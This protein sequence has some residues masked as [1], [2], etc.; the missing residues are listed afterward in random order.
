MVSESQL[1]Q[2]LFNLL[3]NPARCRPMRLTLLG[4]DPS[5]SY[6]N[7]CLGTVASLGALWP[8]VVHPAGSTTLDSD[9]FPVKL[10]GTFPDDLVARA[11]PLPLLVVPL[12]RLP[13]LAPPREACVTCGGMNERLMSR[14][15]MSERFITCGGMKKRIITSGGLWREREA[16]GYEPANPAGTAT[17]PSH[18]SWC[19]SAASPLSRL[20]GRPGEVVASGS[21]H[22]VV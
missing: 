11:P 20:L 15:G 3:C 17:P 13:A 7:G 5:G 1:P 2:K 8:T 22:V 4:Y 19:P 14:G 6:R 18:S 10:D 16:T 12:C 9:R 21:Q